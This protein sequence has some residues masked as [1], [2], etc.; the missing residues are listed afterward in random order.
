MARSWA[1]SISLGSNGGSSGSRVGKARSCM[2]RIKRLVG[3]GRV[4]DPALEL[5]RGWPL[6]RWIVGNEIDQI[7]GPSGRARED[8]CA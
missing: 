3:P 6:H 2:N 4:V 5:S 1:P 8:R 7:T